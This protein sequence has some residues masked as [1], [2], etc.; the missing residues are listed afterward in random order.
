MQTRI[1]GRRWRSLIPFTLAFEIALFC[2]I[3]DTI[4][5]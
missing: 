4:V 1:G 2:E 5:V 3:V